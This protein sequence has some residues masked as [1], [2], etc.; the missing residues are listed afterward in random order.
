MRQAVFLS[1]RERVI[2]WS[3]PMDFICA[4]SAG[5]ILEVFMSAMLISNRILPESKLILPGIV[6]ASPDESMVWNSIVAVNAWLSPNNLPVAP[7]KCG[8]PGVPPRGPN[9]ACARSSP[10]PAMIET[11]IEKYVFMVG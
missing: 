11:R 2:I 3:S 5:F 8:V 7:P 6:T 9:C 10:T 1:G 4:A